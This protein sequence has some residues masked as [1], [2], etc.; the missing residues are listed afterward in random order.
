MVEVLLVKEMGGL[1][2]ASD[3]AYRVVRAIR[4]G[5]KVVADVRNPA[6]RSNEQHAFWFAMINTLYESQETYKI[7][8]DF[9]W[10]LLIDLGYCRQYKKPDGSVRLIPRSLK[11]GKMSPDEFGK[12]VDDTL[13]LAE[14]LGFDRIE[15]LAQT[16]D[17][18]A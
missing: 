8:D 10:D 7:F 15:L 12:L 13:D 5:A 1:R 11:F 9:R 3:D 16:K 14:R 4:N 6:R 18:T 17:R 2:P